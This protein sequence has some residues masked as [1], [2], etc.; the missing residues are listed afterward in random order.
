MFRP[1]R[2]KDDESS[3]WLGHCL[4]MP[5]LATCTQRREVKQDQIL[6]IAVLPHCR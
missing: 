2:A 6:L 3:R 5:T 4:P 1:F